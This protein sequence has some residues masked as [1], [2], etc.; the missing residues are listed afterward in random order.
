MEDVDWCPNEGL[1]LG[2]SAANTGECATQCCKPVGEYTFHSTLENCLVV[3]SI[4][5]RC[6]YEWSFFLLNLIGLVVTTTILQQHKWH[7]NGRPSVIESL[8]NLCM[9]SSIYRVARLL[10][11][12]LGS[13][14]SLEPKTSVFKG[15][16]DKIQNWTPEFEA[17][18]NPK[19]NTK[20]WGM[21]KSKF[22]Y[23]GLR[24]DKIQNWTPGFEA[25]QNP[26]LNTMVWGMT[27]P[28]RKPGFEASLVT[29]TS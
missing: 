17:W 8:K 5:A 10:P 28:K 21:T 2:K 14:Y 19:L 9:Q 27:K 25:W 12:S 15:M 3:Q 11:E 7:E 20:V 26:N 4:W 18:Q 16:N 6:S 13:G 1:L 23:Q 24:H 22:E 29:W